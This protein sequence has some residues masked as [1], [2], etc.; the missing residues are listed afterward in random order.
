MRRRPQEDVR[1][2]VDIAGRIKAAG[3]HA[4][5][6]LAVDETQGFL[7]LSDLGS[8]LYLKALEARRRRPTPTG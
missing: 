1:P 6:V 7:L 3:L 4:P 2:F 8:A 5:E